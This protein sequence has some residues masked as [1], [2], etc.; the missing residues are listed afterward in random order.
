M[1]DDTL[2]VVITAYLE[3]CYRQET[4]PRADELARAL[5]VAPATL[6]RMCNDR[7]GRPP[8]ALLKDAQ[9][10][11]ARTLLEQSDLSTARVAYQAGYG[12][13][14]TLFRAFIRSEGATPASIRSR[15]RLERHAG[16]RS[17]S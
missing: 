8:S 13:R 1:A 5:R 16:D 9:A 14:R 2:Q 17:S 7:Y 3:D 4:A 15:L 10:E 6:R 12:S 11:R